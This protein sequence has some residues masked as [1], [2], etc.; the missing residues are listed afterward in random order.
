[1]TTLISK[2]AAI[3]FALGLGFGMAYAGMGEKCGAGKCGDAKPVAEKCG[4]DKKGTEKCGAGKPDD[5]KKAAGKCGQSKPAPK[6][7]A[8]CGAGKCG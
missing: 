4:G 3:V 6:S 5:E 2:S 1:M 7:D 8:K